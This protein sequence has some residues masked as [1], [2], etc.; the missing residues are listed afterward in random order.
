[1]A[2]VRPR[3]SRCGPSPQGRTRVARGDLGRVVWS[4]VSKIS[5]PKRARPFRAW[6]LAD[7]L[8]AHCC[9]FLGSS[10][11]PPRPRRPSLLPMSLTSYQLLYPAVEVAG[12]GLEPTTF[13]I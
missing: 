12:V 11:P 8:T 1:M 7:G 4:A 3:V 10:G 13:R 5:F 6:R 2:R 9:E